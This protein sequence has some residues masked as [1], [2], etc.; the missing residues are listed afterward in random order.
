MNNSPL[1]PT[2]DGFDFSLLSIQKDDSASQKFLMLVEGALGLSASKAA[3]KYG[4]STERYY[5]LL[6]AFKDK[7][8]EALVDKKTGPK[9]NSVRTEPLKN[10]I[11]RY[12]FLDEKQTPAVIAQKLSQKGMKASERSVQRVIE[13]Y[14]LQKKTLPDG[15]ASRGTRSGAPS[16]QTQKRRD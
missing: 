16:D 5:Q 1:L 14:G 7:G 3:Q 9:Q 15:P 10:L 8:F 4:F 12:K 2:P 13:E 11:I 6:K